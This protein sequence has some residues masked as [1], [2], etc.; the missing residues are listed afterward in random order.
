MPPEE[1][2]VEMALFFLEKTDSK[3]ATQISLE[4][5][6]KDPHHQINIELVFSLPLDLC[7]CS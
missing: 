5:D 6:N 2:P 7:C 4:C 3:I 1:E